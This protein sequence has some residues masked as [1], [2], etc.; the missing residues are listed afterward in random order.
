MKISNEYWNIVL[1]YKAAL[2]AKK[3]ELCDAVGDARE[4]IYPRLIEETLQDSLFDFEEKDFVDAIS[5][6]KK[7]NRTNEKK[8]YQLMLEDFKKEGDLNGVSSFKFIDNVKSRVI[9]K[10]NRWKRDKIDMI[11][12]FAEECFDSRDVNAAQ[13]IA[14]ISK[15]RY[16]VECELE[17]LQQKLKHLDALMEI[18][19]SGNEQGETLVAI[20]ERVSQAK[21]EQQVNL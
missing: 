7:C 5:L 9:G 1:D 10:R 14:S 3:N 6:C 16:D 20:A 12:C 13:D 2:D 18:I 8:L 15:K 21:Q 17:M 19:R 11:N 4:F